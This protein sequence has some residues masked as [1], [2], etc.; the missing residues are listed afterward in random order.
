MN[1]SLS[2]CTVE[3][4]VSRMHDV[5]YIIYGKYEK[6]SLI[7]NSECIAGNEVNS[8]AE[9]ANIAFKDRI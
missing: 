7:R 3:S 8:F 1:Y 9:I 4:N 2:R 6:Q 5:V